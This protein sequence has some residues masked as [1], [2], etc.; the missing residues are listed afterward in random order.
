MKVILALN[1]SITSEASAVYAIHYCR[2][3]D[4]E[5]EL[6]HVK[7]SKDS[8]EDVEKS[9]QNIHTL[10]DGAGVVCSNVILKG[11]G[12]GPLVAY[13]RLH[14]IAMIFCTARAKARFFSKSFSDYLTRALMPCDVAVVRIANLASVGKI[15]RIGLSIS[16]AKLSVEK[17]TFFSAMVHAFDAAGEIYSIATHS[18]RKRAETSFK[19][20]KEQ[21]EAID[22]RLIHYRQLSELQEMKLHLKHAI[23]EN[24]VNQMLHH[25]VHANYELLVV[26]G[27]RLS[28]FSFFKP[29][30]S[31][32]KLMRHTSVNM[33]AFYPRE[34]NYG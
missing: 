29:I 10:A 12:I 4:Y 5:L 30:S 8:I 11:K 28:R 32:E 23:A 14:H 7:N 34:N 27:K 26:G 25:T 33:I 1:G 15:E 16:D 9:M 20:A 17:Y 31:L 19:E 2:L 13:S 3:F 21:L 6:L 24:E 22:H 18:P